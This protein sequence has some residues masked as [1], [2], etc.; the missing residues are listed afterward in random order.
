MLYIQLIAIPVYFLRLVVIHLFFDFQID[1]VVVPVYDLSFVYLSIQRFDPNLLP[2]MLLANVLDRMADI[3]DHADS[4]SVNMK[5]LLLR[6]L[7]LFDSS[8][9]VFL[10]Y[11]I[12]QPMGRCLFS[13][14]DQP[15]FRSGRTHE[16]YLFVVDP[17]NRDG[18]KGC[19]A[20][21]RP[22]ST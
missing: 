3:L 21:L 14:G 16:P 19:S 1:V 4:G 9:L 18:K 6:L 22:L 11:H 7:H 2:G 13:R 20:S 15:I 8:P 5:Q 17:R 10:Y 12:R